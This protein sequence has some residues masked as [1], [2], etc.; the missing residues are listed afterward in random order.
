[1]ASTVPTEYEDKQHRQQSLDADIARLGGPSDFTVPAIHVDLTPDLSGS[2]DVVKDDGLLL[3]ER[4][5]KRQ[6]DQLHHGILSG[7][8][9]LPT[10]ASVDRRLRHALEPCRGDEDTYFM[11]IDGLDTIICHETVQLYLSSMDQPRIS[12]QLQ[13]LTT[14]ICG[15]RDGSEELHTGKRLFASLILANKADA[16]AMLHDE[17]I[18]DE[19]LPLAKTCE[20]GS[21]FKLKK[22]NTDDPVLG[23]FSGW[24]DRDIEQFDKYQRQMKPPFFA[25]DD[26]SRPLHYEL[27]D[28]S[29]LPW[30]SYGEKIHSSNNSEVRRVGIHPA[31]HRLQPKEK[32]SN[33][34]A[35]KTLKSEKKR[36]EFNLEV[37]ALKKIRPNPHL[38][39]LLATFHFKGE[40]HL[41]F[42]WA[43]GG[44]LQELWE[45]HDPQPSI[46]M[47]WMTWLAEQCYGL[48][49]GLSHIHDASMHKSELAVPSDFTKSSPGEKN[50]DKDYGR[51]GDIKPQNILWFKQENNMH[52]HG[53]LKISDFGVTMFH[54]ELTTKVLPERVRGI[55]QSYAAP[56]YELG[57]QVSRPYD[58][59]SLGCIFMEF[60]TWALLGSEGVER[61]RSNRKADRDSRGNFTLDNFYGTYKD[62]FK[63]LKPLRKER[64]L[65]IDHLL[66]QPSH[67]RY[68][69]EFLEYIKGHMIQVIASDR[70]K[71]GEVKD[72]LHL[73]LQTCTQSPEYCFR[74]PHI[75]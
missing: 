38:V 33:L 20:V 13:E 6:G 5:K 69:S 34:F 14:Y 41:L 57:T 73:M 2:S 48:A 10:N 8:D 75:N 29:R 42:P 59:W 60:I 19:D 37:K 61:F 25:Q 17:G 67:S 18:H 74:D 35:L 15:N 21:T 11:P 27:S 30:T 52:G 43:E 70:H 32:G 39:T 22:K 49:E 12:S 3:L 1:M 72:K 45:K 68:S 64:V 55:T 9:M 62:G 63:I 31:Q 23:C 58:I 47:G 16:V 50:D 71:C 65:W 28:R 24:E 40:Y 46:D 56:E 36:E 7:T 53:V 44:N 66:A 51:H 54:S 4:M 26:N